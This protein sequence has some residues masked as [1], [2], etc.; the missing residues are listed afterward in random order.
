MAEAWGWSINRVRRH[1]ARFQTGALIGT[2]TDTLQTVIT[3]NNYG[4]YQTAAGKERDSK[5]DANGYTNGYKEE[6]FTI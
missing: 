2:Q 3:I 1:L 5:R 4:A 6:P